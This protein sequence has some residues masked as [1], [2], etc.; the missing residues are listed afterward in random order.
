M[1]QRIDSPLL[2]CEQLCLRAETGKWKP[3]VRCTMYDVRCS[4]CTMCKVRC[5]KYDLRCAMFDVGWTMDHG[6]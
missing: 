6:P 2:V 1:L 4:R 5:T 3:D